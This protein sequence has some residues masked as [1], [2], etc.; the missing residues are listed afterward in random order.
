MGGDYMVMDSSRNKLP[1]VAIDTSALIT[2]CDGQ[3]FFSYVE[4]EFGKVKY[5]IPTSV[6]NELE[7]LAKENSKYARCLNLLNK[8][9]ER[10]NISIVYSGESN[11]ADADLLEMS[12]DLFV[13]NDMELAG[14]LKLQNKKVFILKKNRYYDYY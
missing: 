11:Y 12:A 1:K 10:N 14:K 8:V 13:T 6:M 9:I 3:D 4:K 5:V 7:K 2:L